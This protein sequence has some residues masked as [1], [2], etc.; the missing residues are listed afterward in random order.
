MSKEN[1]EKAQIVFQESKARLQ[2]SK[3]S[4]EQKSF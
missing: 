3:I 4:S 2:S 1:L